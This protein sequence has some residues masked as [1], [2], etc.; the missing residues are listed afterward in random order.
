MWNILWMLLPIFGWFALG[1]Y[2]VRITQEFSKG[3]FKKL[4][5]LKFSSDFRLGFF[6]FIKAIPFIIVYMTIIS[7]LGKINPGVMGL[8]NFFLGLF[9]CPIL[10][11]NFF[12]KETVGSFFELGILK[13]VFNNLNDYVVVLLKNILLA[14]IFFI[15]FIVLVGIPAGT[16]TKNIFLADFYRRK[17][18]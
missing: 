8:A 16:F 17:V 2:G 4:P 9:V 3:E 7:I 14:V 10:I 5:N 6:M 18:K 15:M 12:I 13:S 11:I 1:G